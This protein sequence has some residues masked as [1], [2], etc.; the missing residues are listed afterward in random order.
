[1]QKYLYNFK[2]SFFILIYF[3]VQYIPVMQSWIFSIITPGFSVESDKFFQD[4][5]NRTFKRI[6]V[7]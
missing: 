7:D 6:F 3:N 2:Q 1:M 5:S 4:S